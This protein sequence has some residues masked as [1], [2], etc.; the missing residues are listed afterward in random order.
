L[1]VLFCFVWGFGKRKHFS[2]SPS[3]VVEGNNRKKQRKNFTQLRKKRGEKETETETKTET[4]RRGRSPE[5]AP[6]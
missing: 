3:L 4:K 2:G 6:S 5:G 1:V